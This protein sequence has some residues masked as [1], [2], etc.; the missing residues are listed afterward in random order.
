MDCVMWE[1]CVKKY[2]GVVTVTDEN[3]IFT[4][5]VVMNKS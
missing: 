3:G 5:T 1:R 2:N 4:F